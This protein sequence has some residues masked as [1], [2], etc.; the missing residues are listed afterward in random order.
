VRALT[1]NVDQAIEMTRGA[2]QS[3][4]TPVASVIV[5]NA[6][7]IGEGN[8]QVVSQRNP[9]LHAE[10][11]AIRLPPTC[12]RRSCWSDLVLDNGN[13]VRCAP[14]RF[15]ARASNAWC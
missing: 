4:N 15:T 6:I 14:G 13:R 7:K 9:I 3:G 11:V 5:K 10:M 8:N 1:L 2:V 12:D